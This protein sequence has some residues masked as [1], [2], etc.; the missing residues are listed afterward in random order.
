MVYNVTNVFSVFISQKLE[1]KDKLYSVSRFRLA[2]NEMYQLCN[3]KEVKILN[4][5]DSSL[6]LKDYIDGKFYYMRL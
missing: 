5:K 3:K 2:R 1:I 4:E 6:M